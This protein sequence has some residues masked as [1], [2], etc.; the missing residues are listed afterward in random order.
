VASGLVLAQMSDVHEIERVVAQ[1]ISNN[2]QAVVDYKKGREQALTYMVG[3]V[4]RETRGRA[5]PAVVNKLL[6]ERLED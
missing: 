2:N 3:Q 5:N 1:V 6:K 4:M